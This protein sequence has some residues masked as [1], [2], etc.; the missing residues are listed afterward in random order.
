M[1][2]RPDT[3]QNGLGKNTDLVRKK[4]MLMPWKKP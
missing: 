3:Q 4:G 2:G 1:K